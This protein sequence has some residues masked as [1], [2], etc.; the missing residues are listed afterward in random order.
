MQR[1]VYLDFLQSKE[2]YAA[3]N[4]TGS[5]LCA[6]T[7][8]NNGSLLSD[9]SRC[10]LRLAGTGQWLGIG[11][12]WYTSC[13]PLRPGLSGC[14]FVLSPSSPWTLGVH[15][16]CLPLPPG[17]SGCAFVTRPPCTESRPGAAA[18][19]FRSAR[20]PCTPA[21]LP[22]TNCCSGLVLQVLKK[23]ADHPALLTARAAALVLDGER[24]RGLK[25]QAAAAA[26]GGD[27]DS[28]AEEEEEEEGWRRRAGAAQDEEEEDA[29]VAAAAGEVEAALLRD[30]K[31]STADASCKTLFVE[32]L[33]QVR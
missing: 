16:S 25:Q 30:L 3:L 1:R 24:R 33:L 11:H 32:A 23:I 7:V 26:A 18:F 8:R 17:L 5:A 12:S 28:D 29:E 21:P 2:V 22:F 4:Q 14:A 15:S 6:L 20:G 9:G 10:W 13:L 31:R 19:P 27:S